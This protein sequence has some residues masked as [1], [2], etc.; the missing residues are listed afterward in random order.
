MLAVRTSY[1]AH[2]RNILCICVCRLQNLDDEAFMTS[3]LQRLAIVSPFQRRGPLVMASQSAAEM[4]KR[5]H[6]TAMEDARKSDGAVRG[7]SQKKRKTEAKEQ[8]V[9]EEQAEAAAASELERARATRLEAIR[10]TVRAAQSDLGVSDIATGVTAQ[11]CED[12]FRELAE[13]L[14]EVLEPS[15]GLVD[16]DGARQVSANIRDLRDTLATRCAMASWAKEHFRSKRQCAAPATVSQRPQPH[17]A[18]A[19]GGSARASSRLPDKR[20]GRDT[21]AVQYKP[22]RATVMRNF[23]SIGRR[24]AR[25]VKNSPPLQARTLPKNAPR[26]Q[27][28][29][30]AKPVRIVSLMQLPSGCIYIRNTDNMPAVGREAVLR[31]MGFEINRKTKAKF[32]GAKSVSVMT[33]Q[34]PVIDV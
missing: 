26:S 15:H 24:M 10:D 21:P 6:E 31:A 20:R 25:I 5:V 28:V 11:A 16:R 23:S 18:V 1:S 17:S 27:A 13:F 34:D 22:A 29:M 33:G 19:S 7:V 30:V 4:I 14:N 9:R 32:N 3:Y 2:A 8:R 12:T